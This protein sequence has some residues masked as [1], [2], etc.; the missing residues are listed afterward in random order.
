MADNSV[1]K[2]W[3]TGELGTVETV[4][5]VSDVTLVRLAITVLLVSVLIM[6]S[7]KLINKK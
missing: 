6:L 4:I 7:S 5:T 3:Q 1:K 2:W